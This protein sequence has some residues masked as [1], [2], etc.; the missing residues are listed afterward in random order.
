ME[1]TTK[2][3]T[4]MG[5][6]ALPAYHVEGVRIAGKTGTA[7]KRVL[8]E[9]KVG[10]INFAWYVCFAPIDR[11]EIAVAVMLEGDTLGESFQG[12]LNSAPVANLILRKYFEKRD[13]PPAFV[14]PFKT[15]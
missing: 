9:G 10:T 6:N 13:H 5:V 15:P 8:K 3:G 14:T 11:P 2:Y 12:G 7:Q 1:G 4:A